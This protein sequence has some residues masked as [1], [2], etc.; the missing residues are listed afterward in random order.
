M[1]NMSYDIRSNYF[2]TKDE[3]RLK[4]LVIDAGLHFWTDSETP[5]YFA[6]GIQ[7][8]Y[9]CNIDDVIT[10]SENGQEVDSSFYVEVQ[11]ILASGEVCIIQEN[12]H[13][14]LMY[15]NAFATIITESQIET[16][17]FKDI[18]LAKAKEMCPDV[19]EKN[20]DTNY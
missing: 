16:I 14:K 9:S 5:Y 15:V 6:F 11:K 13:E 12:C 10:I 19:S 1:S 18:I 8:G 2:Q 7:S 20:L 17:D 4:E 3:A